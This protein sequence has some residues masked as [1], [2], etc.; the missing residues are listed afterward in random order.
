MAADA[1]ALPVTDAELDAL[2]GEALEYVDKGFGLVR[3]HCDPRAYDM[4]DALQ[5]LQHQ[6]L[7][8]LRVER[9]VTNVALETMRLVDAASEAAGS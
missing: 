6:T 8:A 4:L 7:G 1:A 2:H 9:A 3:E 5:R